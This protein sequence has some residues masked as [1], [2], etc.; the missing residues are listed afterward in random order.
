MPAP[1]TKSV[2]SSRRTTEIAAKPAGKTASA[3]SKTAGNSTAA[4]LE[5]KLKRLG[6]RT[7]MDK[8]LHLPARYED[9]TQLCRI[10][11]AGMR[12]GHP[13]QVEGVVTSCEVAFRPRRQLIVT[14]ADD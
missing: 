13:A 14:I 8:V 3:T 9:E 2:S 6:L 10:S 1:R 11:D 5:D 4:K 7:D 12:A